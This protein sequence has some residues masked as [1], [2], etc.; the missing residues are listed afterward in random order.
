MLVF[1]FFTVLFIIFAGCI[2]LII[3]GFVR[4]YQTKKDEMLEDGAR[5]LLCLSRGWDFTRM[6]NKAGFFWTI[7]GNSR[8][9][10]P[11]KLDFKYI[12]NSSE[13][14]SNPPVMLLEYHYQKRNDALLFMHERELRSMRHGAQKYMLKLLKLFYWNDDFQNAADTLLQVVEEGSE[15]EVSQ[16]HGFRWVGQNPSSAQALAGNQ[17]LNDMLEK[18]RERVVPYYMVE[19]DNLPCMNIMWSENGFYLEVKTA[20]ATAEIVELTVDTM[21]TILE[22]HQNQQAA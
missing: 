20:L 18:I 11:W 7:C 6:D 21:E 15:V 2:S 14:S 9:G 4:L 22:T 5:H 3:Y 13:P 1:L 12:R 16:P 8:A 17:K 19:G 10:H